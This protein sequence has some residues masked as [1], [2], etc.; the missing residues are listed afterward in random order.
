MPDAGAAGPLQ[1]KERLP[2]IAYAV[3]MLATCVF[4][5]A[6]FAASD[7][8][9]PIVGAA[10][11]AV[12]VAP[13]ARVL[14]RRLHLPNGLAALAAFLFSVMLIL[15]LVLVAAPTVQQ[16]AEEF[17]V[18]AY[19][20]EYKLR[21]LALPIDAVKH[22]SK[23]VEDMASL[24]QG[25]DGSRQ[26]VVREAGGTVGQLM[27]SAPGFVAQLVLMLVLVFFFVRERRALQRAILAL[28]PTWGGRLRAGR[29]CRLVR[30]NA[31]S[32]LASVT[33][34]NLVLGMA[35]A[36]VFFAIDMPQPWAWGA[37]M[38]VL[39]YMPFVG[40]LALQVVSF[41]AALIVYPSIEA[42]LV[43]PAALLTLNLLESNFGMPLVM[44]RRFMT[45]PLAILIGIAF[46]A[47]LWGTAGAILAVPLVV[48]VATGVRAVYAGAQR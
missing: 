42:A 43:P 20:V 25:G 9:I 17:P 29:V 36:I 47:W 28:A 21:S 24:G 22:W 10:V 4:I 48:M 40:P 3:W 44:E 19:R 1:N 26:V 41:L 2:D 39:N 27:S 35:T 6:M 13:I 14:V 32:Y 16:L 38:M 7:V 5:A 46:G 11:L 33:L 30:R 45:S 8:V 31:V 18:L 34:I 37:A 15:S 23:T 12:L